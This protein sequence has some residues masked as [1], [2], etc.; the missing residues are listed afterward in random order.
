MVKFLFTNRVKRRA[1]LQKLEEKTEQLSE[2]KEELDKMQ[3]ATGGNNS[4]S[5]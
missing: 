1:N 5:I 2:C 4:S 3:E